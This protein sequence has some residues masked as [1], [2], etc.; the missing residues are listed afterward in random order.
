MVVEAAD[1]QPPTENAPRPLP[2]VASDGL[3][4]VRVCFL[5][6]QLAVGG[7]EIQLLALIR[8]LDRT[9][10]QP[11]LVLLDGENPA[12][13]GLEPA[14]CPVFRFGLRRLRGWRGLQATCQLARLLRR[15]RIDVLQLYLPNVLYLGV[16]A[17]NLAGVK[18][19]VRTRNNN[20]YWMTPVHRHLGWLLNRFV[21]VTLCNSEAASRAV[22]ADERPRPDTVI[23]IENGVDLERFAHITPVQ[24]GRDPTRPRRV[25]MVANLRPVKGVDVFVR[26]AALVAR[27]H[28][29]VIFDVAG[30][31]P[32]RLDLERL[33]ADLGLAGRFVLRGKVDDIPGYL[34]DLDVAVLSSRAEGMPNAVLE[35]MAAG[36]PVVATA[37]GG[38]PRLIEQGIHGMIVPPEDPEALGEAVRFLLDNPELAA[39]IGANARLKVQ[40]AFGR[41][42]MVRRMEDF[43]QGL[44]LKEHRH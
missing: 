6:D 3:R 29:G 18:C 9:R 44:T 32:R 10:I 25:G 15:E 38:V 41:E 24:E 4:P 39:R 33:V 43:Y 28:P 26:A 5:I 1:Q 27:S 2:D 40:G 42:A 37:V 16:L 14:D 31:G 20:N 30:E 11:Y 17:G 21:T 22:L 23:V 36:R 8:K 34:A 19:I 35:S 13:R 7:T 12:S